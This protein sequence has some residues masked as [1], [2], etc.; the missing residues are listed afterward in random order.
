MEKAL[1]CFLTLSV[2]TPNQVYIIPGELVC[3]VTFLSGVQSCTSRTKS[4]WP[5]D[6]SRIE[7]LE[8]NN[9]S[10]V[11]LRSLKERILK[12]VCDF[13]NSAYIAA[14]LPTAEKRSAMS[15]T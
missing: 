2:A 6:E 3:A 11:L 15:I 8:T 4:T 1:S 13:V 5:V 10:S 12:R 9:K 7:L 14:N